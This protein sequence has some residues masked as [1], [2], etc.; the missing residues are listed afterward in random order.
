[1]DEFDLQLNNIGGRD[2]NSGQTGRVK[3]TDARGMRKRTQRV[4][5]RHDTPDLTPP[6]PFSEDDKVIKPVADQAEDKQSAT[7]P[8]DRELPYYEV[9]GAYAP[10]KEED[11]VAAENDVRESAAASAAETVSDPETGATR[12]ATQRRQRRT[13]VN[14]DRHARRAGG[15]TA[16]LF[17]RRFHIFL[18]IVAILLAT[19]MVVILC[20]HLRHAAH[21]QSLVLNSTVA[22][23]IASGHKVS[24]VGGA[25]GAWLGH[26]LF[27]DALGLGAFVLAIYLFTIGGCLLAHWKINF[28]KFTFKSLLLAIAVSV[29]AGL[30]A[31]IGDA[32]VL[33]GG[34]HGFYL[35]KSL[36]EATDWIGPLLVT[37]IVLSAAICVFLNPI[38]RVG[39]YVWRR[40]PK[41]PKRPVAEEYHELSDDDDN[42]AAPVAVSAASSAPEAAPVVVSAQAI[43]EKKS[44]AENGNVETTQEDEKG[45][46]AQNKAASAF[47]IDDDESA[48]TDASKADK[49]STP[50]AITVDVERPQLHGEKDAAEMQEQGIM[51]DGPEQ[52][53]FDPHA[54]LPHFKQPPLELLDERDEKKT[55]G[56]E[57]LEEN[58]Q[59]IV[60]TLGN[61]NVSIAHIKATVGPTIT[62]YE[63]VPAEGVR[64]STI[65]HLEDDIALSLKAKGIRIIAPM[66]GRGTVGIEVPNNNPQIV[67][68]RKMLE[69]PKFRES[70]KA[71][72]VALGST[73]SNEVFVTDLASMPHALVAGAT[74]QGKSVG[75]NAIIASLIYK[76]HPADLKFVLIDPKMV[77]FS[78]Y[79]KLEK[80]YLAK[81]PDDEEDPIV[82][83]MN[84]VLAVLNSLCVEMDQR[85][86]LMKDARTRDIKDYNRRFCERCLNPA[87]G[88]RYMPY[89]VVIIDEFSDLILTAG[90]EVESP[91]TRIT[92]KARAVGIHMII[93]TQRPSTN[94]LTGLIKANCPTRI[95]FRVNQMVD[96]RTILDRPGANQL[97]GRG[98]ML[99]SAGGAME[100]VQCAFISTEEV[101]R[102][103]DFVNDQVGFLEPYMLPDPIL[104]AGGNEAA[105]GG[106]VAGGS[107]DRDPL[108]DDCARF[109]VGQGQ[110]SVSILQRKYQIGY[111]R[112]GKIMD[113]LEACGVVSPGSGNKPRS[114]LV[115]SETLETILSQC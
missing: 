28:W 69:A 102:I 94:V 68:M 93:A 12:E 35:H 112:A 45:A 81:L 1:M 98:D 115:D 101:E 5:R 70:S 4:V 80:H 86:A 50:R 49:T 54:E 59:K 18:G 21:D 104:A 74:G 106:A 46:V 78:L 36:Y 114:I 92:Q 105:Q 27:T 103:C 64:I 24:N 84:R 97:I 10:G 87:N 108:F 109:L 29:V 76:K 113:Q 100:R 37:L 15:V 52:E 8:S 62:L 22:K 39:K 88:H 38:V 48:N 2:D 6:E 90:K 83:D 75:L 79:S 55:V 99:Y 111:N 17:D 16:F 9:G 65:K 89:I 72:P 32:A 73:I 63:I 85:Y 53:E 31:Y 67:S 91:V 34:T 43:D 58:I 44:A 30:V 40:L 107:M 33:W 61:Y 7:E 26:A 14:A 66:P 110:A 82:T 51:I 47:A 13:P 23:M 19:T 71:L 56:K 42:A 25:V 11:S 95:A 57:E 3:A 41:L 77:E 20:S 60:R 96:S